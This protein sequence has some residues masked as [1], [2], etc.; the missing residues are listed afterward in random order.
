MLKTI[1]TAEKTNMPA[2]PA[3]G[4][5]YK[6]TFTDG[7]EDFVYDETFFHQFPDFE[8]SMNLEGMQIDT[9]KGYFEA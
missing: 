6:L 8:F 2:H 1:Q 7:S 5:I 3:V 4:N 9:S